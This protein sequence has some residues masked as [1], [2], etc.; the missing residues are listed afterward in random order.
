MRIVVKVHPVQRV[1][2][3]ARPQGHTQM[4]HVAAGIGTERGVLYL[5]YKDLHIFGLELR[6]RLQC[7]PR[8]VGW[9]QLYSLGL[10][11]ASDFASA[12][13]EVRITV[14]DDRD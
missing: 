5:V 2:I 10:F 12:E 14:V 8:K 3:I 13:I 11:R 6:D 4:N 7:A 1:N 9:I